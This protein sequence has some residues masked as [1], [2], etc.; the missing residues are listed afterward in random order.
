MVCLVTL[1]L[2]I[3][4]TRPYYSAYY[5]PIVG[6]T[7]MAPKILLVGWGEG[8]D[9]AAAYLN[10]KPRAQE[11]HIAIQSFNEFKPFFQGRVTLAGW[12]PLPDPDYFVLYASHVQ[13]GFVPEVTGRLYGRIE[14]EF[15]S[16]V[17]GLQYAWVYP[18]VFYR[19]DL[20]TLMDQ[21]ED[22]F[23]TREPTVIVNGDAALLR[24]YDGHIPMVRMDGPTREDYVLTQLDRI[25][26]RHRQVCLIQIPDYH[27]DL[28]QLTKET[29]AEQLPKSASW[30]AGEVAMYCYRSAERPGQF[31]PQPLQETSVRVGEAFVL[32]G[33]DLKKTA[34][35]PGDTLHLRLYWTSSQSVEQSYTVFTHLLGPDGFIYGQLDSLP[36][37]GGWPTN[38]W[39]P[40]EIVIDDY[41]ILVSKEAP[42]GD[43]QL[44]IGMYDLET[45]TRLPIYGPNGQRQ[46]QDRLL[47]AK[48]EV[49][50][51]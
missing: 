46:E 18:N 21:V 9:Q 16:E 11:L 31:L 15:V 47:L 38:A 39:L 32:R 7:R 40:G 8:L 4:P 37:G 29:L 17:N 12:A 44:E 48:I 26:A 27:D 30:Q 3:W 34:I 5:N 41:A 33:Y 10:A 45:M 19:R 22:T 50:R 36:Q 24:Y 28:S 49:Q 2:L 35:Q 23:G 42:S 51:P 6:G 14:P 25:A 20:L 13:R 1:W 43:Y